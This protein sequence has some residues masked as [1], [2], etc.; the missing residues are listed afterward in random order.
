MSTTQSH[1]R[2]Q[3]DTSAAAEAHETAG[4]QY[5]AENW[6]SSEESEFEDVSGGHSEVSGTDAPE[7]RARQLALRFEDPICTRTLNEPPWN[8]GRTAELFAWLVDGERIDGRGDQLHHE[9]TVQTLTDPTIW[10][11]RQREVG[12]RLI[13]H[14]AHRCRR[15]FNP[16]TGYVNWGETTGTGIP[17]FDH[18]T[19]R[20]CVD[21]YLLERGVSL[22]RID[23]YLEHAERLWSDP[24]LGSKDSLAAF[25]RHVRDKD[26]A[27]SGN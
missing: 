6:W 16:E 25:I 21:T 13:E 3:R 19:F 8:G 4:A 11:A 24:S 26:P 14:G 20:T 5:A 7:Q 15:R 9:K 27:N 2:S 17:E 1:S 10:M 18:N 12:T 22:S 23:D